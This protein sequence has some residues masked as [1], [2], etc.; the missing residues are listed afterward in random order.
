M[1]QKIRD[2]ILDL[3]EAGAGAD[4][5]RGTVWGAYNAVTEYA[6]HIIHSKDPMKRLTSIWFGGGER[7]KQKALRLAEQLLN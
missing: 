3:H 1:T 6:D 5:S 2:T 7:L 4:L